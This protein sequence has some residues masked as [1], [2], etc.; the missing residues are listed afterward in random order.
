MFLCPVINV[1]LK[2]RLLSQQA[3][4]GC[5]PIH[6]LKHK[7]EQLSGPAAPA[8]LP[9]TA[10]DLDAVHEGSLFLSPTSLSHVLCPAFCIRPL[11]VTPLLPPGIRWPPPYHPPR[12]LL[13]SLQPPFPLLPSQPKGP[14]PNLPQITATMTNKLAGFLLRY[15]I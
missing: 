1:P 3:L 5:L 9:V 4:A 11:L 2:M 10:R 8:F 7:V 15:R 14:S 13:L 12:S 6:D